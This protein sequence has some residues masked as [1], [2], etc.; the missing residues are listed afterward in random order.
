MATKKTNISELEQQYLE[1][2]KNFKMLR[3]QLE[4]AKKEEEEAKKAKFAQE[5]KARK[6]EVDDA[7]EKAIKLVNAWTNDFGVYSYKSDDN[8]S[9]F[10]SKFWNLV[11]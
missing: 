11:W 7:V 5:K 3:E 8:N 10:G 9:I 1:A 4:T 6:K 2:E